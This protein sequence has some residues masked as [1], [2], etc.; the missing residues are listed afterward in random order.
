M[1]E[2]VALISLEAVSGV[3][4]RSERALPSGNRNIE[5]LFYADQISNAGRPR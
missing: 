3:R 2:E 1:C 5:T 4:G